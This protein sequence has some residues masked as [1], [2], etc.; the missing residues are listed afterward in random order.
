MITALL[1]ATLATTAP[2]G[3]K[4]APDPRYKRLY[5]SSVTASS[6]LQNN[7]NKYTE[8]YHPNYAFDDDPKTAWVE[9]V[10]GDGTGETLTAA[11][12]P[13]ATARAVKVRVRNGYQKSKGLLKENAAPKNVELALLSGAGAVV[14]EKTIAL[15]RE[16]GWQDFEL[17][18]P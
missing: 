14:F 3:P 4:D 1:L 10:E 6:Y 2:A 17:E 15:T 18:I 11:V 5:P 9:G 13:L 16:L 8:N 12:S 7:W